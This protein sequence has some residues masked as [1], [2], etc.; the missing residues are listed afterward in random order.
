[1]GR[2]DAQSRALATAVGPGQGR[3]GRPA[4]RYSDF[5]RSHQGFIRCQ[6][7]WGLGAHWAQW[8]PRG[9]GA[10][11]VTA[12][13]EGETASPWLSIPSF[14]NPR[15]TPLGARTRP[16]A[17]PMWNRFTGKQ[18]EWTFYDGPSRR[19][20]SRGWQALQGCSH[21]PR[22]SHGRRGGLYWDANRGMS[23]RGGECHQPSPTHPPGC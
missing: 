15:V 2:A 19:Q 8:G 18:A 21:G 16:T 12:S 4:R 17:D 22:G 9:G 10:R 7:G 13:P 23:A 1:M 14:R 20:I 3:G 11:V 6:V 5:W